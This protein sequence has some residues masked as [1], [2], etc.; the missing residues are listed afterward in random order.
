ME[1]ITQ[2]NLEPN[3]ITP[4]FKPP[5]PRFNPLIL[6]GVAAIIGVTGVVAY[7]VGKNGSQTTSTTNTEQS[8]VPLPT[9]KPEELE[10][11]QGTLFSG[12]LK[13]LD[14]NLLLFA[15]TDYDKQNGVENN[16]V[17]YEAGKF[18]RGELK[19]Y[20]RIIAVKPPMGPEQPLVFVLATKDYKT[21]VLDDPENKTT[22]YPED[23]W[24]NPYSA[25]DKSKI[26]TIKTFDT[27]LPQEIK[28][29]QE[30]SLYAERFPTEYVNTGV[31][32]ANGN[33][34]YD[35][36][37]VTDISSY[38]K[39]TSPSPT[40][41]LYFK[42]YQ[43][44]T[45]TE[46]LTLMKQ[47]YLISDTEVLATDST[48]LLRAYSLTTPENIN[49]YL[50]KSADYAKALAAYQNNQ[51]K[52]YP[53]PVY[54][55]NMGFVS[56]KITEQSQKDLKFFKDY[57]V[58]IP[59]ACAMTLNTYAINVT[60]SEL[61]QIGTV[62]DLP[63]F[64]LK[65]KSHPL[66]TLAFKNKTASY[67]IGFAEWD[68]VNKGIKQPTL[69]EYVASNP[70]LFVKD[71]WQRWLALGEYDIKLPGG[72][73]KPV[74]YLYPTVPTKVTVKFEAPMQFTT[75]IPTYADYWQVMANPNGSLINLRPELTKCEQI[76]IQK[77]GSEYA[78][79]A[80]RKN[81]YPYL[82]WAGSVV[83][84]EYPAINTGWVVAKTDV[85][86][87]LRAK[88]VEVGLNSSEQADFMSYWLPELLDKD[89]K[90]YRISFLQTNELN[91]LFPMTVEPKPDTTFR[92]FL[93]YAAL[94]E[95]PV[96]SL[97]PQTLNKLVRHG[98]TLVEWGGLKK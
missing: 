31:V 1:N 76:D 9:T 69:E 73:G 16:F 52:N 50:I 7:F 56:S 39:L 65:D 98:F 53:D 85:E 28:L 21:Y 47:K 68:V 4:T 74:V 38:K 12:R 77:T 66:Y 80:C 87:F 90:Y 22:K 34:R 40:V 6:V 5:K 43:K 35:P 64:N 15:Y 97:K 48:G 17:Y 61:E 83:S 88:L 32:D 81:V 93:D 26:T 42:P 51:A 36:A 96:E 60:D 59:G 70:L 13:K 2:T 45:D 3:Q 82:Y 63:L 27:D 94:N 75:D 49:T 84:S 20:T 79:E 89:S 71:Y 46:E 67:G 95:V 86:E 33:E 30:F 37:L 44:N 8:Q 62:N 29:D 18:T 10:T 72:C 91:S 57:E 55:P 41:I 11:T 78:I 19:D 23:D 24:Q 25:L 54:F 92:L 58:A 14:Q